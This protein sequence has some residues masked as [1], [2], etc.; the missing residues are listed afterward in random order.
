MAVVCKEIQER[1]ETFRNEAHEECKNISHTVSETICSWMPWPLDD[2][3]DL[4]T[5]V[6]TEVVCGIVWVVV[7]V[8]S[9]VTRI[10]CETIYVIDWIIT[11]LIGYLEWLINRIITFP[12]WLGCLIGISGFKKNLRICPIVIADKEGNPIVSVAEINR[13]IEAAKQIWANQCNVNIISNDVTIVTDKS[14]LLYI[15][16]CDSG[17]YFAS[18]RIDLGR[19]SCCNGFLK[20][21]NCLRFPSGLIWPRHVLKCIWV[22]SIEGGKRGCYLLPE[23][24]VLI[25]S[26][27]AFDTL[28]HEIGHAGDLLHQTDLDNLMTTP[29]RTGSNLT[30]FQCCTFRT[31][32]FLTIF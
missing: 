32:R 6:V 29:T 3:C 24:F 8:V 12:E 2:L 17:G 25:A 26:T 31:S 9:W 19:L 16:G 23:S 28:A 5:K 14:Y 30:S 27:S 13:Q 1:I 7:T 10:V 20:S 22:N 11:H 15:S 4:V 21:L 18:D